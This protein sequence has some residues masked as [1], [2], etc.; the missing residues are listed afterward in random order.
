MSEE[1]PWGPD[2]KKVSKVCC[3]EREIVGFLPLCQ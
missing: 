3:C 2:A 1:L